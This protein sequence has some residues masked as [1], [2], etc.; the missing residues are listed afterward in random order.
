MYMIYSQVMKRANYRRHNHKNPTLYHI[1]FFIE[2]IVM[3]VVRIPM[4]K[5]PICINKQYYNVYLVILFDFN[6]I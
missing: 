4:F 5:W 6:E 3:N 2:T 1:A